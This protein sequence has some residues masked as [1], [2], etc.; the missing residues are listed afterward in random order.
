M[1]VDV[2]IFPLEKLSI[3]SL[4]MMMSN[5]VNDRAFLCVGNLI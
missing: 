2:I 1:P 4:K 3:N 5:V